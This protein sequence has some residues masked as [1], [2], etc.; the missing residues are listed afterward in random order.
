MTDTWRFS[1]LL[2]RKY[3]DIGACIIKQKQYIPYIGYSI[4]F[5]ERPV[6]MPKHSKTALSSSNTQ[7]STTI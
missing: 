3:K 4:I 5:F 6:N 7:E 1:I 2:N